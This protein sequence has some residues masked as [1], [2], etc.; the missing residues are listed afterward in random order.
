MALT[1]YAKRQPSKPRSSRPALTAERERHLLLTHRRS[2]DERVR[3]QALS[4]LWENHSSLVVAVA[5]QYRRP[6]LD[7]TDLVGAGHLGMHAAIDGFDP[8]RFDARLSTYAVNWIR[9]YIQ[10]YIRR[11]AYP[12][13]PPVSVAHRQLFRTTGRLFADARRACHREGI[14]ATDGELCARVGGRIGLSGDEVAQA[15]QLARGNSLSLDAPAGA[16]DQYVLRLDHA[17]LRGRV[18]A[19][20]GEVLGE[21]E[22]TVFLARC[23]ADEDGPRQHASLAAELGVTRERVYQL[24]VSAKRK[25]VAAL[26]RR[27]AEPRASMDFA[28]AAQ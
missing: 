19:L 11:H 3:Q 17:K 18:M 1:S 13:H 6:D 24:E 25:I 8:D 26:A 4:E 21:R 10:D 12:V 22:R 15:L 14:E 28:P 5:R 23:M 9:H 27:R 7:M 20:V 2:S 16:P